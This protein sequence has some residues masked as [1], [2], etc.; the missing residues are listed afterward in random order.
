[1]VIWKRRN[2]GTK[3][4]KKMKITNIKHCLNK[5]TIDN[6]IGVKI[7]HLTG[8][9]TISVFAI[10]LEKEQSIP[11]HY[12]KENIETY[13]VLEGQGIVYTGK[14]ENEEVIWNTEKQV[15]TGDCFTIYPNQVHGFKN[16]SEKKLQI[17]AS[18]PIS[19]NKQDRY[20][21]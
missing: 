18:A 9:E 21:I 14:I 15:K 13:F 5:S 3:T 2:T 16:N 8:D 11:V 1:M 17:I 12:H 4:L 6:K 10:E 19:H 20:F 7:S